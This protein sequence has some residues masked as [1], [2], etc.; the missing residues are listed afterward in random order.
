MIICG[1]SVLLD[2]LT[3][4]NCYVC[5]Q[6]QTDLEKKADFCLNPS[7]CNFSRYYPL[8]DRAALTEQGH[9]TARVGISEMHCGLNLKL[10]LCDI[11]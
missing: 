6:G 3:S 5:H 8:S 10:Y 11:D 7:L 2:E 4:F 1:S 9:V